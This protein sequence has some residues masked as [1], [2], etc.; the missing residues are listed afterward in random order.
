M[1]CTNEHAWV[2]K[3][4]LFHFDGTFI[5]KRCGTQN[6]IVDEDILDINLLLYYIGKIERRLEKLEEIEVVNSKE[7]I[8]NL[9]QNPP[10]FRELCSEPSDIIHSLVLQLRKVCGERGHVKRPVI[11]P[12]LGREYEQC[13]ECGWC[14]FCG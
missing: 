13:D 8:M 2:P 6:N 11:C 12:V 1:I 7:N 4:S 3:P 5:C 10:W 9:E 14:T